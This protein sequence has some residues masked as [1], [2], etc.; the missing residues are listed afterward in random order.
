MSI[1]AWEEIIKE[2]E[3]EPNASRLKELTKKLNDAMLAEE[4]DKVTQRLFL[5]TDNVNPR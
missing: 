2:I 4:R 1:H 5:A 3:R